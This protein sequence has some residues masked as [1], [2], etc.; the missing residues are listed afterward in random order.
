M[1]LRSEGWKV[2]ELD[3]D[4][5][6]LGEPITTRRRVVAACRDDVEPWTLDDLES[7]CAPPRESSW[8]EKAKVIPDGAWIAGDRELF[9]VKVLPS[10]S[11]YSSS[12]HF[13]PV[14]RL[15]DGPEGQY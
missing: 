9:M 15:K 11:G 14:G 5:G 3:V 2:A 6:E 1:S 12:R 8:L 13:K 4:V 10:P 7:L